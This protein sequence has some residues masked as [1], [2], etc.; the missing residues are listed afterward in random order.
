[1]KKFLFV[2]LVIAAGVCFFLGWVQFQIPHGAY[3]IIRS[4]TH[5]ID[6]KVVKEGEFRWIWYKLLPTN[7]QILTFTVPKISVPVHIAGKLPSGE[8]YSALAGLKT[9]FSYEFSGTVSCSVSAD[10]LPALARRLNLES[11]E[12]LDAYGKTLA[13]EVETYLNQ[14]FWD[15]S[16]NEQILTQASKTG[17][18][19]GLDGELQSRFPGTENLHCSVKIVRFPDF[20]LYDQVRGLYKDYLESQ[21]TELE[22]ELTQRAAENI[23]NQFRLDELTKYGE[24]LAKYPS[25]I[26]YLALERGIAPRS[27]PAN[28]R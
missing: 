27:G 23:N 22:G 11:Q 19:A 13:S 16:G 8:V 7:V 14:R 15:Y 20:V 12:D 5:G 21:K 2:L 25:L 1:M 3:G 6:E 4:K 10:S 9:D 28:S 18:I 24:L 26:D 17:T